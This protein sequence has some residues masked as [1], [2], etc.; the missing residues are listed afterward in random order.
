MANHKQQLQFALGIN[1]DEP[2]DF[3]DLGCV[4]HLEW[5]S[6]KAN[7]EVGPLRSGLHFLAVCF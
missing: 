3:M 6:G 4:P 7:N 1:D 2:M 5:Q